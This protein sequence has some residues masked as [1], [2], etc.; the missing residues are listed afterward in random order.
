M[1]RPKINQYIGARHIDIEGIQEQIKKGEY[2][3]EDVT[4]AT[5]KNIAKDILDGE[6]NGRRKNTKAHR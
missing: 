4:K 3:N 1:E 6:S 5:A 2:D